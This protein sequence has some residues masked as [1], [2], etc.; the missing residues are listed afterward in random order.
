M[1]YVESCYVF[2]VARTI[3]LALPGDSK[4]N[5]RTNCVLATMNWVFL[6]LPMM[7]RFFCHTF[8]LLPNI[9]QQIYHGLKAEINWQKQFQKLD[10]FK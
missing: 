3:F 8:L 1:I 6:E 9:Q 10:L 2:T 4:Q 7:S 5:Q